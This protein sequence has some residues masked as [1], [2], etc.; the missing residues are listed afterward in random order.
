MIHREVHDI[1]INCKQF[2]LNTNP[3]VQ[4]KESLIQTI[5]DGFY[6]AQHLIVLHILHLVGTDLPFQTVLIEFVADV[7]EQSG[8][9]GIEVAAQCDV[10]NIPRNTDAIAQDHTDE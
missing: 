8:R 4:P 5:H 7:D 6:L 9:A 1:F 2:W 3:W 10:V